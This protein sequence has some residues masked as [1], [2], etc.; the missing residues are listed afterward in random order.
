MCG[1]A[2]IF[3][4]S[5]AA[6][7][8]DSGELLKIRERMKSRGPDGEGLWVS[9]A[10]RVGLAHRRLSIIDLSPA[11]SQ[12]MSSQDGRLR[13]VF[14]GEIY[15]YRA[16]RDELERSGVRF[17]STSDT[18]VMLHLYAAKG[19]DFVNDLRGMFAFALWDE[20]EKTLLLG[21][22]R[23]G[24]KPLYYADGGGTVRVASQVK[25]LLAGGRLSRDTDPAGVAG[26]FLWGSVPEPYTTFRSV[27]ALP[28]GTTMLVSALGAD[29]PVPYDSVG[30]S[31]RA[32]EEESEGLSEAEAVRRIGAAVRE[33]VRAH[34]VADVPVGAFLSAG[35]DSN[36]VVGLAAGMSADRLGT[37]TLSFEEFSGTSEDESPAAGEMARA[38]GTA[39][40]TRTVTRGEFESEIPRLLDAMDQPTIDGV[41]TYFVSKAA[42]EAGLKVAL[43]GLGG[44]EVFGGY[45]AF[46]QVPRMVRWAKVPSLVPGLGRAFRWG[47]GLGRKVFGMRPKLAGAVEYG[48]TYPGAYFL[49]R[50]LFMPWELSSVMDA[51]LAREGLKRLSPFSRLESPLVPAPQTAFGRVAALEIGQYMRNQLLRDTDWASMA[52]G[53]EVRVPLVDRILLRDAIGPMAARLARRRKSALVDALGLP[54]LNAAAARPKTGFGIPVWDWVGRCRDLDAWRGVPAL[55][56]PAIHGSRRWAY[57]V[58]ALHGTI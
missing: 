13:I 10:R 48:G 42:A 3:A 24:I 22:D 26:F 32:A 21:R 33:S 45:P 17:F 51:D 29:D 27:R 53:L 11:G 25:A 16:L 41:N 44:D 43:S 37:V 50:G 31:I 19:R 1:I 57:T 18:E 2:A 4:Y 30:R 39:H 12:P 8:V 28:A 15:N 49:R 6:P 14:N 23:F 5:P 20:K 9:P 55:N 56:G 36:A 40:R 35:V 52:H 7:G 47:A 38:W 34:L 58:Y 46:D 54:P